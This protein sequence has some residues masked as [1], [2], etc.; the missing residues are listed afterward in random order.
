M[1]RSFTANA[2][3]QIHPGSGPRLAFTPLPLANLGANLRVEV[4][5]ASALVND[6]NSP[7]ARQSLV[8]MAHIDTGASQTTIASSLAQHLAL[9]QTGV[10]VANTA[11]GAMTSP[12][13]AAD[14]TFVGT[15]LKA[16]SD[17]NIGS[18]KLP[19]DL[20]RHAAQPNDPRN[21]GI[22]IGRDIMSAWHIVWDGPSSTIMIYD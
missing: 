2:A 17:L 8:I 19:F 3:L 12:T 14:I 9:T 22:L 16:R 6:P 1:G 18:C 4:A 5:T 10:G 11:N 7:L 15:D 13:Y 21:F 20:Q